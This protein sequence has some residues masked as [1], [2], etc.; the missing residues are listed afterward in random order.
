[1]IRSARRRQWLAPVLVVAGAVLLSGG[2]IGAQDASPSPG[3]S[4]PVLPGEPNPPWDD[5]ATPAEVDPTLEN[6]QVRTWDHIVVNPDGRTLTVY[7]WNGDPACYGLANVDVRQDADGVRILVYT[8][9]VPG[10]E[11]CTDQAIYYRTVV[12]LDAPVIRGG[13]IMDLPS[14]SLAGGVARAIA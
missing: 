5:G 4:A 7:F 13:T 10:A 6:P 12:V 11:A 14:G 1:M 9:D 3:A 8:G 2:P